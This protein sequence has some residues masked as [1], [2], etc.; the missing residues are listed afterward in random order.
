MHIRALSPLDVDAYR[1]L[2][3]AATLESP[4]A[5]W[6][7][8]AEESA[9]TPE[10][11]GQRLLASPWQTVFGGFIDG[12]LV[13]VAGLKRE[14]VA[15]IAHR[16]NVWGIYVAPEQR[17]GGRARMLVTALIEH[18]RAVPELVQLTLCVRSTNLAAKGLYQ[19]L[20]FIVTGVD[21]RSM[22]VD[23]AYHDEDRMLLLLDAD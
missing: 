23:G 2:R 8:H 20:G 16:A 3:L 11:I 19:T 21:R 13:A 14:A 18:A 4:T 9:L 6:A 5:V 17:G 15:K 10:Q 7:N 12:R 1:S 22:W